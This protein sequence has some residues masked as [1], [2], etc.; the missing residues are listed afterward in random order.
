MTDRAT[1][2]A[3]APWLILPLRLL[4]FLV[5]QAVFALFLGGAADPWS[6]AAAYWPLAAT[7]T[8]VAT[9]AVLVQLFAREARRYRDILK[10]DRRNVRID[11][12]V[13]AGLVLIGA[14]LAIL[15]N[16]GLAT[17]L[18]GTPEGALA[19]FVRPL[20]EWLVYLLLIAFPL[21]IALA[22][23]PA[24]FA[25][26]MPR[27]EAQ[28]GSRLIAMLVPALFLAAQHVTLP[29]LFDWRFVVWRLFMFVPFA[30]FVGIALRWRPRLLPYF[31]VVHA[32]IDAATMA[33]FLRG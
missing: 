20:P 32:L 10:I 11:L 16:L 2:K 27:I 25:Y 4:G 13:M 28:T 7:L 31:L 14:P 12:L 1:A 17:L 5:I 18:F 24:Y 26:A 8:N 6:A 9:V 21:T 3:I 19:L 23:L 30:L 29:L 22:E 15:P 33:L